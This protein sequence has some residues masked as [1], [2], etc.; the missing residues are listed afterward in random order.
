M[1]TVRD[2]PRGYPRLATFIDSDP[3]FMVYRRF[4]YSRQ[5]LILYWQDVVRE[6]EEALDKFDREEVANK[7]VRPVYIWHRESDD[8][9]DPPIRRHMILEL[10]EALREY[11]E[12]FFSKLGVGW[13]LC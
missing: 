9:R 2:Q 10:G 13:F 4:G 6:K 1:P 5:R 12:T 7:K 8:S 3:A 11:G